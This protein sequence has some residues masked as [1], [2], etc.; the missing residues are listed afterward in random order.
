M[1]YRKNPLV[2]DCLYH[3]YSKSIASFVIFNFTDDYK[4][5]IKLIDFYR[6][7]NNFRFSMVNSGQIKNYSSFSSK[8]VQIVAYCLMPT[9]IHLL[10][11][12]LECNGITK[13]M[14]NVLNS[15]SKYFNIKHKRKGPLWESHFKNALIE[16]NEQ[17]LH[18]TRYIHLNPTTAF[19]VNKPEDWQYSSYTEFLNTNNDRLSEY[20]DILE[21]N[22]QDYQLFVNDNLNY[23]R[24]LAKIKK[25]VIETNLTP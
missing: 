15:Y 4:R 11:K 10:L 23:Q 13:F 8:L 16:S 5:M 17:L 25:T 9:H 2:N 19:L 18:L 21:I 20:E 14:G 6:F 22:P 24:E 3:I 1:N 7:Q 12:Q